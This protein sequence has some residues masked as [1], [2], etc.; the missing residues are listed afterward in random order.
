MFTI[1]PRPFARI[2]GTTSWARWNGPSTWTSNMSW[3]RRAVNSVT[4]VK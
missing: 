3:K 4:G 2:P 1:Q